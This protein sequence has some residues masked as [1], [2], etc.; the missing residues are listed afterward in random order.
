M[1]TFG[2][3]GVSKDDAR[4]DDARTVNCAS[5][6]ASQNGPRHSRKIFDDFRGNFSVTVKGSLTSVTQAFRIQTNLFWNATT[7]PDEA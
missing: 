1:T 7:L 2:A 3:S 5:A 6:S 4:K